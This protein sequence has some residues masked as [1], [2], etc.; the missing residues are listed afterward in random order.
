MAIPRP[1]I[2][3][4]LGRT[5][6][7]ELIGRRVKLVRRGREHT[8][9]CPFH[10]EKTPSFT[11]NEEKGFY[12]C[13]G[14]GAHGTAID[15]LMNTENLPFPEAVER[16]A[17]LAGLEVPRSAPRDEAA[18]A[19]RRGLYE[20]LEMA[21]NWFES[22]LASMP[23]ADARAY[24]DRR[25]VSADVA[26]TFRL[27]L[28][29]D[30]RDAMKQAMLA[31]DVPE[32]QLIEAGLLIAPED[33]G[34]TYD[35]FRNRL[36]F[37]IW[38][39]RERIVAFGGRAL[40]EQRAKYLNS[41]ETPLFHKGSM[42][43]NLPSARRAARETGSVIVTE[44]YM[45]VIALHQAGFPHAVAPLGTALTED[46]IA[47]L[48][49]L[50][51]E[52]VLCFDGDAAGQRAA[53][54]AAE[55]VLPLLKPGHSLRFALLPPGEDPDSLIAAEGPAAMTALLEAAQPLAEVL[56]RHALEGHSLDTPERRAGLRQDLRQLVN[57]I[58]DATVKAYYSEEIRARLD[59]LSAERPGGRAAGLAGRRGAARRFER[60]RGGRP[61]YAAG[62]YRLAPH[63]GLGRGGEAVRD[64]GEP[65][66]IAALL[67]HPD[68]IHAVFEDVS[69][70]HLRS[71]ELDKIR[72]EIIKSAV[73]GAPL[74]PD[75]LK[76][77]FSDS[78]IIGLIE[79]L[80][81][82]GIAKLDPFARPD[83]T[84]A[85]AL[86]GWTSVFNLHRLS[87]LHRE[88]RDAE[89]QLAADMTDE[90]LARLQSAQAALAEAQGQG[91]DAHRPSAGGLPQ[92]TRG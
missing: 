62:D 24:L 31:R 41:P 47:L 4:L 43:Y 26:N 11:V 5:G 23:G 34:E 2:E 73:S 36:M 20:V 55:R 7:V 48:W 61:G 37:P 18:E 39:P 28:A 72:G 42:L 69:A 46:Q 87:E 78:R 59:A 16:L 66:L 56:W 8:G 89:A 57:R 77:N 27:G 70:L 50:T 83:A 30:R 60:S 74:D 22:Q 6:L 71:H 52:P 75:D 65:N 14:C 25:G 91:A 76:T 13:F 54:R 12:H 84:F 3:E 49:R 10:N 81:G 64:F 15:F 51:P 92:R 85:T 58:G 82:P 88:V 45:D 67:N 63:E 29:P 38:D 9:L 33:G 79:E 80:T 32:Q 40:G 19:R 17:G 21:A 1:F 35:R 53:T 68:L 90:N 44:G 86:E